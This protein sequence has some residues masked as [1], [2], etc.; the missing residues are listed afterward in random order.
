MLAKYR[1]RERRRVEDIYHKVSNRIIT[2]AKEAGASVVVLEKLKNIRKKEKRSKAMNGR[3]NRWSFRKFQEI[4]EY[5]A[6][7]AGL[8]VKYID[9]R[10]TSSLCPK[11]GGN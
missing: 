7:L 8:N 2:V 1:G 9:A 10:W 3:L 11:C 5:K 6:K 4:I